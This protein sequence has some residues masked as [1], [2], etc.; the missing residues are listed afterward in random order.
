MS[1]ALLEK[2]PLLGGEFEICSFANS[3]HV[4]YFR[5]YVPETPSSKRT[6]IKRSLKTEERSQA[7]RRA[8]EEWRKLKLLTKTAAA[9]PEGTE[10]DRRCHYP[11]RYG[12]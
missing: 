12:D 9:A 10:L 2:I 8:Y 1:G 4:W 7:E 3:P 6:Y 11:C 5:Q